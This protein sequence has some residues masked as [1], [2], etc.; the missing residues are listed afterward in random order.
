MKRPG[1]LPRRLARAPRGERRSEFRGGRRAIDGQPKRGWIPA[2]TIAL[3]VAGADWAT[4]AMIASSI[5]LGGFRE[6]WPDRVAFWHLRNDAMILGLYSDLPLGARKTIAALSAVAGLLLLFEIIGRG[7]R[8]QRRHHGWMWLFVGLALG[9]MLGNLGE[10]AVHWGVTDFLSFR[11]GDLW[12]PPGNIAD[13]ALFLSIPLSMLLI[14]FELQAR[15]QRGTGAS[16][17]PGERAPLAA[18]ETT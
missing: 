14:V 4:K 10:R 13:L 1:I 8:L 3:A 12:L 6:V 15:S 2:V 7:H 9:G 16:A 18:P 11:A 5:P 17:E